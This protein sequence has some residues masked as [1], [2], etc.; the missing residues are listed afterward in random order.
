M[1]E[2]E[3]FKRTVVKFPIYSPTFPA[4]KHFRFYNAGMAIG[5]IQSLSVAFYD[6]GDDHGVVHIT[7]G[8]DL[9]IISSLPVRVH[10]S[11]VD[12]ESCQVVSRPIAEIGLVHHYKYSHNGSDFYIQVISSPQSGKPVGMARVVGFFNRGIHTAEQG[13]LAA[14]ALFGDASLRSKDNNHEMGVVGYFNAVEFH[15]ALRD[16]ANP[17]AAFTAALLYSGAVINQTDW[18]GVLA[19]LMCNCCKTDEHAAVRQ[20]VINLLDT[21][22]KPDHKKT[23][24]ESFFENQ[25]LRTLCRAGMCYNEVTKRSMPP[26]KYSTAPT[27]G[28]PDAPDIT[29]YTLSDRYWMIKDLFENPYKNQ[30][31]KYWGNK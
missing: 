14:E 2:T 31:L 24:Y 3:L 11:V 16:G 10:A 27:G 13:V 22:G 12:V 1:P 8:R 4:A 15:A 21:S 19:T 20:A 26:E 29:G 23:A 6:G 9:V 17:I 25:F 28:Q 18:A 30:F 7:E 5:G